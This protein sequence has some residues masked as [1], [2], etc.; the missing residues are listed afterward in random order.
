MQENVRR[1]DDALQELACGPLATAAVPLVIPQ[2]NNKHPWPGPVIVWKRIGGGADQVFEG[3]SDRVMVGI[4]LYVQVVENKV[5]AAYEKLE[6]ARMTMVEFLFDQKLIVGWP[7][8]PEDD[9]SETTSIIS[10]SL[11]VELVQ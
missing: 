7:D 10:Q 11:T 4:T 3:G 6:E 5:R 8:P 9:Y 2:R 1:F